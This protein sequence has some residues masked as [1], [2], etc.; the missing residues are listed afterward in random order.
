MNTS[1]I[2]MRNDFEITNNELNIIVRLAQSQSGCF[3]ARMTGGGFGGCAIALV[4]NAH[5][6]AFIT[7]IT[8]GYQ[9][10]TGLQPHVYICHPANGAELV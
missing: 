6:S 10:E 3:G 9:Q 2:S 5:A 7:E 8:A 1:H 4:E